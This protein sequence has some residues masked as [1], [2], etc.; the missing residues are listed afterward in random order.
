[1]NG[2]SQQREVKLQSVLRGV[3]LRIPLLRVKRH[4]QDVGAR[5]G[6]I[7]RI[8]G[9]RWRNRLKQHAVRTLPSE[10]ATVAKG[11]TGDADG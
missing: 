6:S 5:S 11:L 10:Q 7:A 1:M 2:I 9:G 3:A 4:P 8:G